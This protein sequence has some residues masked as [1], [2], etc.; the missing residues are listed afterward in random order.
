MFYEFL[1]KYRQSEI[2]CDRLRLDRSNHTRVITINFSRL[3]HKQIWTYVPNMIFD[4]LKHPERVLIKIA[5][6]CFV[7]GEICLYNFHARNF[8]AYLCVVL[9]V[10]PLH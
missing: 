9:S 5:F 8:F 2:P 1:P 10:S 3:T 6:Y 7:E 4:F